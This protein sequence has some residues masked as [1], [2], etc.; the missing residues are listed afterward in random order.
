M[1]SD[2]VIEMYQRSI[3]NYSIRYNPF[4][5]DGDSSD[6]SPIERE[7]PYGATVFVRKEECVNHVTKRMR[8]N[9]RRLVKEY[10]RQKLEDGKSLSGIG[11]LTNSRIDAI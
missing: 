10:K 4:V 6:Y 5:G 2:G 1:E 7:H 9:L 11:R 8:T 3:N